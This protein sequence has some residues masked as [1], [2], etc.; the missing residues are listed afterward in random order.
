M[1]VIMIASAVACDPAMLIA[2]ESTTAIDIS[3]Q[4]RVIN[5]SKD[6]RDETGVYC[7]ATVRMGVTGSG[8]DPAAVNVRRA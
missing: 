4:A 6:F 8:A 7:S 5:L 3:V 1:W 2:D